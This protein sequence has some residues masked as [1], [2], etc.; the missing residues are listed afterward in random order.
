M[1]ILGLIK[2]TGI[3]TKTTKYG[4]TSLIVT[5]LTKDFGKISAIANNVRTKR[6]R[7]LAGLQLFAYSE[8]VMYKAKSKNG[9]YNIDEMNVL[10]GFNSLRLDLEKMAYA[11]YFAE[12]ANGAASEDEFEEEVISLLLNSLY[13]LDKDLFD[14]K[15]IKMVFEWRLASV[16]GYAPQLEGCGGCGCEDNIYGLSLADGTVFCKDCLGERKGVAELSDNMR[17]LVE[18]ISQVDGKRIFS[19]EASDEVTKY[20]GYIGEKYLSVQLEREFK[21][22]DYLKKVTALGDMQNAEQN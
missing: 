4:E 10:E 8:I 7:M 16:S 19:F 22:L 1:K 13:A 5:I 20:L 6:S 11:S 2:T 14:P 3:V 21:T 9:L 18:Y 17:K 15:K 12:A